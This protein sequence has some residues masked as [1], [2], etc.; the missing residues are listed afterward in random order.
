[1]AF[2]LSGILVFSDKVIDNELSKKT[3]EW[4]R[5]TK[6]GRLFLEEAE[7]REQ[8]ADARRLVNVINNII[9]KGYDEAEACDLAGVTSDD[10]M[11]A[12]DL[13]NSAMV[14]A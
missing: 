4:I 5:M 7:Q 14:V 11:K 10:Y 9:S 3:K 6:V 12:K 13:L 8:M 2:V 1:M